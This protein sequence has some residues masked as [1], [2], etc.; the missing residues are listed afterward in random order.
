MSFPLQ[1]GGTNSSG[2]NQFKINLPNSVD[3][4]PFDVSIGECFIYNAWNNISS[5]FNNQQFQLTIP[6]SGT[7]VVATL[8]VPDGGYNI[9]DLNNYLQFWL[10]SQGYYLTNT[11]TRLNQYYAAF[12]LSPTSY[13][14]QFITYPM[15]TSLPPGFVSGGMTFPGS[16]NQHYQL[17]V[18]NNNFRDLIGY[19]IGTYPTVP[20]NIGV[21]TKQSDY[22]PNVGTVSVVQIRLSCVSSPFSSNNQLIHTFA[23]GGV[24]F[25]ALINAGSS[26]DQR[27]PCV[28]A[29]RELTLS[30]FDQLG[31]PLQLIDKNVSIKLLF[32]RR[33]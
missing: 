19:N 10:I 8:T 23:A 17:T 18:L 16:S 1:I 2:V 15:P 21:Q 5:Q 33:S 14:I 24:P 20:T 22:P 13:S 11:A 32:T 27:V 26:Y 29:H 30:L 9:A 25:G 7:S 31:R 12:E 28:G 4:S 6:T 3:L